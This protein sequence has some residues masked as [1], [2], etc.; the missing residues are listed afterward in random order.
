MDI[1]ELSN[2]NKSHLTLTFVKKGKILSNKIVYLLKL[3][4]GR[5]L[6]DHCFEL[7]IVNDFKLSC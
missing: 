6:N 1:H 4:N 5:Q 7:S 3:L 2:F